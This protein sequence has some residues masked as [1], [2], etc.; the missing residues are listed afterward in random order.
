MWTSE[1]VNEIQM[2]LLNLALCLTC[3]KT[4]QQFCLMYKRSHQSKILIH[5]KEAR[6]SF[7]NDG[8][9]EDPQFGFSILNRSELRPHLSW[10]PWRS[11]FGLTIAKPPQFC[12]GNLE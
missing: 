5:K 3:I 4:M 7:R 2:Y 9:C 6:H 1:S 8:L 11:S 10:S 12:T